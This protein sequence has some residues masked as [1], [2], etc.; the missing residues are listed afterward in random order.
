MIDGQ[1]GTYYY[2]KSKSQSFKVITPEPVLVFL[3]F[4]R[5]LEL[6]DGHGI[7]TYSSE[8]PGSLV[9]EPKHRDPRSNQMNRNVVQEE[10]FFNYKP[11]LLIKG[12]FYFPRDLSS[13]NIWDRHSESRHRSSQV[14]K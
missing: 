6:V 11:F 13:E 14:L 12:P 3:N 9:S 7:C 4:K 10:F 1:P 5:N 8:I 2:I